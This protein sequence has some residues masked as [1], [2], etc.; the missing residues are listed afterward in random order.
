MGKYRKLPFGY[1]MEYGEIVV[2]P[3][4]SKWVIYI[5]EQYILGES[6]KSLSESLISAGVLFDADKPWNK[7]MVARLLQDIRYTGDEKFPQIIETCLFLQVDQ[8]RNKK[9]VSSTLTKAQ[10]ILKRKCGGC[11][12]PHIEQ[13]VLYLLN[14]LTGKPER[15]E[16]PEKPVKGSNRVDTLQAEL[17]ELLGMLP[18]DETLARQKLMETTIAMYEA[19]DPREYETHRLMRIFGAEQARTELDCSLLEQSVAAVTIDSIGKVRIRLKN[20]QIL[21]RRKCNE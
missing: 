5:Y 2:D 1:R 15:L 16:I 3:D 12:S 17:E 13:E 10:K 6:Y 9:V 21:E 18:V 14:D 7:N 11:L 20:D 4:E 8:K 19:I